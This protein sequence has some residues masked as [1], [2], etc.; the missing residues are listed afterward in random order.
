V[1]ITAKYS[2]RV[3]RIFPSK[4]FRHLEELF[5]SEVDLVLRCDY[6]L[7]TSHYHQPIPALFRSDATPTAF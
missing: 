3:I 2:K 1:A 4:Q 6:L 7:A 5:L